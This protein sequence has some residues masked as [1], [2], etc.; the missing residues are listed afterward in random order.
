MIPSQINY[1]IK[2][3]KQNYMANQTIMSFYLNVFLLKVQ[4]KV[5]I[6]GFPGK[7]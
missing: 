1:S 7:R 4:A 6:P 5:S 3:G 2:A